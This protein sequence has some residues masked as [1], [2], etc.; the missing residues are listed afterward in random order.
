V[1]GYGGDGKKRKNNWRIDMVKRFIA[2]N[3]DLT[4]EAVSK[5][6]RSSM[7]TVTRARKELLTEGVIL[8]A[9]TGRQPASTEGP[10][11]DEELE[12]AR[13]IDR[14]ISAG[15]V[16]VL[17]REERRQRLS[18]Y[19]D[20]PKVPHASKIAALKELE[21]TEPKAETVLGPGAPLTE[22]DAIER[23]ALM[24]E[25]TLDIWGPEA[26]SRAWSRGCPGMFHDGNDEESIKAGL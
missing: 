24:L 1:L 2:A 16:K 3:P 6:T 19:A 14:V 21:A 22:E 5:A 15:T 10:A 13:D 12:I 7:S 20:H 17:T 18:A 9:S 8:P 25:A 4:V 11:L 23:V 26:V